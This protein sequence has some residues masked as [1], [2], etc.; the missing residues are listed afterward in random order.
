[1]T[2]QFIKWPRDQYLQQVK[3]DFNINTALRGIIGAIE[4]TYILIKNKYCV[5]KYK[6]CIFK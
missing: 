4:G 3:A 5:N 6:Y 1:M 2:G